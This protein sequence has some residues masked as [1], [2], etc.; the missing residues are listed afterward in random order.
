MLVASLADSLNAR[1]GRARLPHRW[2]NR[3]I[4]MI[5]V[6][7][8]DVDSMIFIYDSVD[9]LKKTVKR[10]SIFQLS[11]SP[12]SASTSSDRQVSEFEQNVKI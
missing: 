8:Y 9:T 1:V 3:Y 10:F 2:I 12:C 6:N 4:H 11:S 7:Y 5:M